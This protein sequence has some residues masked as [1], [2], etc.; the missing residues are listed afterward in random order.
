MEECKPDHKHS[1]Y[2]CF[3]VRSSTVQAGRQLIYTRYLKA[4]NIEGV[5]TLCFALSEGQS[6]G[7]AVNSILE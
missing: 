1:T 6:Y 4:L 7:L 2:P 5:C 3:R